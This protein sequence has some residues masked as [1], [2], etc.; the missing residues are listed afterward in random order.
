MLEALRSDIARVD[1]SLAPVNENKDGRRMSTQ[2]CPLQ[3]NE[4]L[5]LRIKVM[6]LSCGLLL[7]F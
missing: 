1:L 4:F 7:Q 3:P 6:N 2:R 5:E